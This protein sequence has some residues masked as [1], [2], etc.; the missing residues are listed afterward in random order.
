MFDKKIFYCLLSERWNCSKKLL[1]PGFN[2]KMDNHI[3]IPPSEK[4][5]FKFATSV[6]T[7]ENQLLSMLSFIT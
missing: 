5:D 4:Y 6:G 3:M 7:K 2:D 1:I